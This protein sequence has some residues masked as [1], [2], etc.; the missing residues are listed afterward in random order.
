M[1]S[2]EYPRITAVGAHL[3][4]WSMDGLP[5]LLNVLLGDMSCDGRAPALP[6]EAAKR[7]P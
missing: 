4:R 6:D 1:R 2:P 3:R 7:R 5:Q